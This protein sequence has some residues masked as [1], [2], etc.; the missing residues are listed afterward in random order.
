VSKATK[1]HCMGTVQ[2]QGWK[3]RKC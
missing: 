3:G 1:C 2:S